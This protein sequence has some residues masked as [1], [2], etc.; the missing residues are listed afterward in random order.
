MLGSML[1]H[2]PPLVAVASTATISDVVELLHRHRIGAVPVIDHGRIVGL[3]SERDICAGL[4]T[5]GASI[6]DSR[7]AAVMTTPVVTAHPS[8]SCRE[9]ME[10]MTDRRFRHLPV[11][12]GEAILGIVSIGDLVKRRIEDAEAEAQAMKAYI[13]S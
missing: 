2:K 3:I 1:G 8:M 9:A 4:H 12:D 11:V 7:V 10:L 13:A 5:E 6:L